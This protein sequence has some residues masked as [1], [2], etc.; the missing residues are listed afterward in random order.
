MQNIIISG[1]VGTDPQT[2]QAGENTVTS[3]SVAVNNPRN[4]QAPPT[5]Y[6]VECWNGL[7]TTVS[8]YVGKGDYVVVTADRLQVSPYINSDG[9]PA[10][11]IDLHASSVD[12]SG[13]RRTANSSDEP[14]PF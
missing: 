13:N 11:S 5:W 12:F 2:R 1:F 6:R 4:R 8:Q 9:K 7:G 10:A 3:F 14:A